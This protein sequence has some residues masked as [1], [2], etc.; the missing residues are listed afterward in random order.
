MRG[1]SPKYKKRSL[2]DVGQLI[3][4][5]IADRLGH[6]YMKDPRYRDSDPE[7][8]WEQF[9]SRTSDIEI[10]EDKEDKHKINLFGCL[11]IYF[12]KLLS[13]IDSFIN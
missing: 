6:P 13:K 3:E 2:R 5:L 1:L 10:K 7:K 8:A 11:M 4:K 12:S 9:H